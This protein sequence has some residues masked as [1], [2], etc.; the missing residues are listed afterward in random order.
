MAPEVLEGREA[1]RASDIYSLGVVLYRLLSGRFPIQAGNFRE[2]KQAHREGKVLPLLDARPDTHPALARVVEKALSPDPADRYR[3]AG[4]M[5]RALSAA[6][7]RPSIEP[8][9]H[10]RLWRVTLALAAV[11]ALLAG[12]Y[13]LRIWLAPAP[14]QVDASFYRVPAKEPSTQ[15]RLLP[16]GRLEVGDQVFLEVRPSAEIHVYVL[17]E[18]AGGRVVV[19]FP[20]PSLDLKNPLE[21]GV[22][23]RLP[24]PVQ[25]VEKYWDMGGARGRESFLVIASRTRLTGFEES[26]GETRRA[27]AGDGIEIERAEAEIR[28]ILRG[29]EG[30]SDA[31]SSGA[32]HEKRRLSSLTR[33]LVGQAAAGDGVW[34]WMIE[35]ENA[36][37]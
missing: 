17:N 24:G 26:L 10:D 36:G 18:D 34:M 27:D 6:T 31:A 11:V 21:P 3:T 30:L 13:A 22:L 16:G 7:G 35:L 2:L 12:T 14:L 37:P 4:E 20:L 1:D 29:V 9:A 25:G 15:D 33:G 28:T 23:H 8:H 32:A 5:Q 19:M